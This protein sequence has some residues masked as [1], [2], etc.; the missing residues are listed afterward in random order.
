M[1]FVDPFSYLIF[2]IIALA[3]LITVLISL[4]LYKTLPSVITGSGRWWPRS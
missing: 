4:L 2:P 3:P 1:S